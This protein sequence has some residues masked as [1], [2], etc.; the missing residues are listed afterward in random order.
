MNNSNNIYYWFIIKHTVFEI[1]EISTVMLCFISRQFIKTIQTHT[2]WFGRLIWKQKPFTRTRSTHYSTTATT[3]MLKSSK[4]K[5]LKK[6][7]SYILIMIIY[8]CWWTALEHW[9]LMHQ[10]S[11]LIQLKQGCFTSLLLRMTF[12]FLQAVCAQLLLN[13]TFFFFNIN[14]CAMRKWSTISSV[15]TI[16]YWKILIATGCIMNNLYHLKFLIHTFKFE[17]YIFYL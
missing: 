10:Q 13:I 6:K 9:C 2:Q 12:F 4:Q 1:I 5:T 8:K 3:M 16:I 7:K 15:S 14:I 17:Y 11:S